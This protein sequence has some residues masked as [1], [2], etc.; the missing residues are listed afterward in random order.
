LYDHCD[1]VH[2]AGCNH[3]HFFIDFL[4]DADVEGL[5]RLAFEGPCW[6]RVEPWNGPFYWPKNVKDLYFVS[7]KGAG[8]RVF[9]EEE[10]FV[11]DRQP[12]TWQ[13]G[14]LMETYD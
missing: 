1:G 6:L 7:G 4:Q 5:K 3:F 11:I 2:R 9:V 12:F 14:T 13:E 8:S 10:D